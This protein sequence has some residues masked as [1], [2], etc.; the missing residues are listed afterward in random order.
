M[1]TTLILGLVLLAGCAG[2][3]T[4]SVA[5]VPSPATPVPASRPVVLPQVPPGEWMPLFDGQTLNGWRVLTEKAFSGHKEV[6][7]ENG[8]ILL[9][10]GQLQTGV[11]WAGEFPQGNYEVSLEAMRTE[12]HDF[13]CGMTFPVGGEPCTL[14]VGGWGGSVV[15]LSNVDHMNASENMTTNSKSFEDKHWYTIR[16]RVTPEKIEVWVDDN[17]MISLERAGHTFNVWWEQEEA[18]PFGI[19]TWDTGGALRNIRLRRL[20]V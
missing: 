1:K 4:V 3:T 19:A 6:L 9:P 17:E 16:L 20:P 8:T 14:I 11:G 2:E 7:V 5:P 13:F 10:R 15:G 18:R 12:G